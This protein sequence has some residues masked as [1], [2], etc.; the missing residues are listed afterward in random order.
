MDNSVRSDSQHGRS[1]EASI[2]DQEISE[3]RPR[4]SMSEK[5]KVI[6]KV[7]KVKLYWDASSL[8][9]P[10]VFKLLSFGSKER[11]V[12]EYQDLSKKEVLAQNPVGKDK[13]EPFDSIVVAKTTVNKKLSSKNSNN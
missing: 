7:N 6:N 8:M 1:T 11:V 9:I 12:S 3:S 10:N 5:E 2:S 4:L 13:R